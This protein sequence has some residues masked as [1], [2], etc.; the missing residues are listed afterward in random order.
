MTHNFLIGADPEVFVFD[1]FSGSFINGHGLVPGSKMDPFKVKYGAVQVDGMALEFNIEPARSKSEFERNVSEVMDQLSGM[2]KNG[3]IV[4]TS[5]AT[6][7]EKYFWSQPKKSLE[8]GCDPDYNAWSLEMNRPPPVDKPMRTAAGHIH[9]GWTEGKN[10]L[11]EGHFQKCAA[12]IRHLDSTVGVW[13]V[14]VDPDSWER[15][16][17][18]GRAGAFRPK[19]YGVEWRVPSNFWLN[20]KVGEIYDRVSESLGLW[21]KGQFVFDEKAIETINGKAA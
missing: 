12:M 9:I 5:V 20:G 1:E 19:P 15:R 17:M 14:D 6:F 7:D 10:P 4:A 11:E 3:K 2:V 13:T 21:E 16:L 18:Y 8:L